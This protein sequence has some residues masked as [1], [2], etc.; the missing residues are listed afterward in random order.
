ML[1]YTLVYDIQVVVENYY[2]VL[3]VVC[4]SVFSYPTL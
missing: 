2:H 3:S 1:I 4:M